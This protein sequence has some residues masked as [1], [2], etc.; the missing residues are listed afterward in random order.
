MRIIIL[1][2]YI[3]KD[4]ENNRRCN[5]PIMIIREQ[6]NGEFICNLDRRCPCECNDRYETYR[7]K[8]ANVCNDWIDFNTTANKDEDSRWYVKG[9][10]ELELE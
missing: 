7:F 8:N 4:I 2:P 5:V 1:V 10:L 6:P 9:R 3:H